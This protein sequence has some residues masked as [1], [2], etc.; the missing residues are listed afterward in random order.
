LREAQEWAQKSL[1]QK[2][3]A[4]TREMLELIEQKLDKEER[5]HG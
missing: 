2:D 4:N 3:D 5:T 1:D